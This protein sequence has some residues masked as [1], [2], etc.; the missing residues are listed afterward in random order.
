MIRLKR[1]VEDAQKYV[2]AVTFD[3]GS[4]LEDFW[5]GEFSDE[6]V[7]A[8][9]DM[10]KRQPG[11]I[12]RAFVIDKTTVMDVNGSKNR[13][14]REIITK[15]RGSNIRIH[16]I[17]KDNVPGTWKGHDTSFLLCDDFVVSESY[18][19][20]DGGSRPGYVAVNDEAALLRLK[21]LFFDLTTLS[22][23]ELNEISKAL[24]L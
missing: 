16:M 19:L 24:G 15:H 22:N 8:N 9:S 23:N 21:K 6:Y 2:Y 1:T 18:S 20:S 4:Y 14:L 17:F 11:I 3:G 12:R 13:I 7:T 10:T 5:T